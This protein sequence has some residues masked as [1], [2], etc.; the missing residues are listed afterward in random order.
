[1]FKI[2]LLLT[3]QFC[4]HRGNVLGIYKN[5]NIQLLTAS[6]A[7]NC[8]KIRQLV[9]KGADIE[10]YNA[11]VES[12]GIAREYNDKRLE[13]VNLLL[14]LGADPNKAAENGR[15]ALYEA[16]KWGRLDIVTMLLD[17]GADPNGSENIYYTPLYHISRYGPC[18]EI[19]KILIARGATFNK[20]SHDGTPS[21][22]ALL[23]MHKVYDV[24]PIIKLL[25]ANGL[26]VDE[27][28]PE[29]NTPLFYAGKGLLLD[30]AILLLQNGADISTAVQLG[31]DI[32]KDNNKTSLMHK[33]AEQGM[34]SSICNLGLSSDKINALS[35][36]GNQNLLHCAVSG[37]Y[38]FNEV[39]RKAVEDLVNYGCSLTVE[40]KWN[41]LPIE[42]AATKQKQCKMKDDHLLMIKSMYN[43]MKNSDSCKGLMARVEGFLLAKGMPDVKEF[44]QSEV[45]KRY[46]DTEMTISE[47][48]NSVGKG[49]RGKKRKADGSV[50]S[51]R[52]K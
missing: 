31:L 21:M 15:T 5:Y 14:E 20:V 26:A 28:D 9:D 51:K 24:R 22:H 25:V 46:T 33:M 47:D 35:R 27:K 52:K 13:T 32:T 12:I 6:M 17:A 48:P 40:N 44:I 2:L 10:R 36:I 30:I 50:N 3:L 34:G 38:P 19:K 7:N 23:K 29:G 1:M 4:V 18:E 8:I 43:M 16:A 41:K 42:L 45:A 11:L 39:Q 49:S 37:H